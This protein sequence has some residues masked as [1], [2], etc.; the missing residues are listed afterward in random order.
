MISA[1][2]RKLWD[3]LKQSMMLQAGESN[4]YLCGGYN[5]ITLVPIIQY[6]EKQQHSV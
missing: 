2:F 6:N 5:E 3:D 1:N 4:K